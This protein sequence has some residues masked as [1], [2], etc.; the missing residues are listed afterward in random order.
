MSAIPTDYPIS[1]EQAVLWG[2]M[3]AFGHVN[4][5]V[6]FRY[7]EDVRMA[8]FDRCGVT[9]HKLATQVGP[10]LAA[11][12]C[13]FRA[14]LGYPERIRI[15]TWAEQFKPKRLT[16]QYRVFSLDQPKLVAEGTGLVVFYDYAQGRS[17]EI[18]LAVLERIYGL[19][20][21]FDPAAL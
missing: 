11:T 17:C 14:P 3:D 18:P 2:D 20:A 16:M 12:Q 9:E 21:G 5:T 19:Q 1:L 10:I 13:D 7:F 4:N 15:V 8:F 6:Y